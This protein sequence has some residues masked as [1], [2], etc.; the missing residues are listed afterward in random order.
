MSHICSVL[1]KTVVFG[2]GD[3]LNSVEVK[4]NELDWIVLKVGEGGGV[5][6]VY[7]D[8]DLEQFLDLLFAL[9]GL[10]Y[11]SGILIHKRED[12]VQVI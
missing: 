1:E 2:V 12:V 7:D 4:A 6:F 5:G 11:V 3:S 8:E 10:F 9:K